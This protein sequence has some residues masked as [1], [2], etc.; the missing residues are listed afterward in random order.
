MT[1]RIVVVLT[2][3]LTAGGLLIGQQNEDGGYI[4]GGTSQSYIHG[5]SLDDFL[6][7][8][9]DAN[10]DKLWRKNYGGDLS[11]RCYA[12]QQTIDGG[13]LFAGFGNSGGNGFHD[14]LVYKVDA[15]GAKQWRKYYGGGNYD[16]CYAARQTADGGYVLAGTT[17]SYSH[18][19]TDILIYKLDAAGNKVWRKN[20]GGSGIDDGR[21]VQQT[22]D[23]GYVVAGHGDSYTTGNYDVLVY[24]LDAAGNKV[25]R[26]NFGGCGYDYCYTVRQTADGGFIT[27]G[28]SDSFS[29]GNTDFLV[30]KLGADGVVQWQKTYG[31]SGWEEGYGLCVCSGGG[32]AMVGSTTSYSHGMEDVLVYRVDASGAKQWRKNLG[33]FQNDLGF[34]VQQ[35]TDGGFIVLGTTY[36]YTSGSADFLAYKLDAAGAKAWR[37]HYGGSSSDYIYFYK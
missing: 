5:G 27:V 10:G 28:Y 15:T 7:Y 6:A 19:G 37:K 31:G 24:R 21:S 36:S 12:F 16:Y 1:Y 20:Y 2:V 11:E 13:F 18:G 29:P 22:A 35:T 9:V 32:Y 30:T 17:Y 8:R 4:L 23:G 25:W 3:F 26:K 33:G 14:F 34:V